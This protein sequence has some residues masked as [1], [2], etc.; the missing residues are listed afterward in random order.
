[1]AGFAVATARDGVEA[2]EKINSQS[3][4]LMLLDIWLP[5][6]TGLELPRAAARP[7]EP[8]QS[9]RHD[10]RRLAGD[11][12]ADAPRAGL[13]V[14]CGNRFSPNSC[15]SDP[16]DAGG[17]IGSA[18]HR[19]AVGLSNVGRS[20]RARARATSRSGSGATSGSSRSI[21][22]ERSAIRWGWCFASCCSMRWNRGAISIRT[23][24]SGSRICARHAMLLYRIADAGSRLQHPGRD[25][26][27]QRANSGGAGSET[28]P[29]PQGEKR[30][31]PGRLLAL[32]QADEL[33]VNEAGNEV[34]V[35]KYLD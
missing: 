33:L 28:A 35:V 13:S 32:A 22:P 4:D 2:L 23:A 7:G 1:M 14:Q 30:L 17:A 20:P 12:A 18:C 16:E 5:R 3:F 8:S 25:A 26:A 6:M 11:A 24:E 34:V 27:C 21:C 9:D 10:G 31:R 29:H 15:G 19:R